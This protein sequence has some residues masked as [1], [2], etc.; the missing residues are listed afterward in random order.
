MFAVDNYIKYQNEFEHKMSLED[1]WFLT[2]KSLKFIRRIPDGKGKNGGVQHWVAP[3]DTS[4]R[5]SIWTDIE[6]SQIHKEIALPFDNPKSKELIVELIRLVN[7]NESSLILDFF[8]GSAT[9]AHAVMQLNAEDG[10]NRQFIMVQ[11]PELCDEK[12]EAYKAGYTTI[13]EIG[14]ERIR[15]AGAKIVG[16]GQWAVGSE[17]SEEMEK[18][19]CSE[20]QRLDSLAKS[21]GNDGRS[22][23]NSK[24]AAKR[25]DLLTFGSNETSGGVNSIEYSGRAGTEQPQGIYQLSFDS[26][27]IESGIGNT[28]S[29]LRENWVPCKY[30]YKSDIGI[31]SRNQQN[32]V[33]PH[34][35]TKH[36]PLTTN[37][38]LPDIGFRVLKVDSSNMADVYYTP[39]TLNQSMLDMMT[40]NIKLGRTPEDLLFQVLLDWGVDLTLPIRKETILGKTIFFVGENAPPYDIVACFDTGLTEELLK[41]LARAN[42]LRVV[43]RDNGFASDA[44][45]INA[46]QIFRQLSSGT[47]VK[48]I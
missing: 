25:R 39:D 21:N 11:L 48:T 15:R 26:Q 41:E 27:R 14:K 10:G 31:V 33:C 19:G 6:V 29:S 12:S 3:S 45:K 4:L 20:L 34:K 30:G 7:Q 28:A 44:V 47:E 36:C 13:A 40:D 8:S 37:H 35:N 22:V 17:M 5:T 38:S 42:P 16:S 46:T 18:Y 1:Y 23:Q 9:T 2:G 43:F 32:A 24:E